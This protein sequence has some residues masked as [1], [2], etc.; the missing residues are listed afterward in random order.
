[1]TPRCVLLG[2][3][4]GQY[5]ESPLK[6]SDHGI[7]E[8]CGYD[9]PL[10]RTYETMHDCQSEDQAKDGPHDIDDQLHLPER[11]PRPGVYGQ[12]EA[13]RRQ[14]REVGFQFDAYAECHDGATQDE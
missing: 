4:F 11:Y 14:H 9:R 2:Y 3:G 13:I 12:Y 6:Q 1:M 5:G 7:H 10:P 8:E